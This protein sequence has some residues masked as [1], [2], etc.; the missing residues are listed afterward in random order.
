MIQMT[1]VLE[2]GTL[3]EP[4]AEADGV[5]SSAGGWI[6]HSMI[7]GQPVAAGVA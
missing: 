2:S 5:G 3:G 4:K 1:I 7:M 6:A